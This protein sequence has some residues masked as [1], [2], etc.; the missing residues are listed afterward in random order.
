MVKGDSFRRGR[1]EISSAWRASPRRADSCRPYDRFG[2]TTQDGALTY[3]YDR[4]S[5]RTEIGYP[6]DVRALYTHDFADREQS[7]ALEVPREPLRAIVTA[8]SYEPFGPLRQLTLGNGLLETH[9][10]DARYFP[11]R[12]TIAGPRRSWIGSTPRTAWGI[13]RRLRI[14]SSRR[15]AAIPPTR[16]TSTI[17]R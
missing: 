6:G 17:S 1:S 2:R 8:A 3:A 7:L 16:T 14:S 4:N 5:N 10:Q 12:I 15:T 11:E 13:R 9:E